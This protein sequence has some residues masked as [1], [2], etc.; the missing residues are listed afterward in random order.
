VVKMVI[1]EWLGC[2]VVKNVGFS[3]AGL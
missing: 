2:V 1:S 3:M